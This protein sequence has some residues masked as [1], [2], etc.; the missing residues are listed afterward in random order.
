MGTD[1]LLADAFGEGEGGALR[2]AAGVYEDEGRAV[3]LDELG[4]AVVHVAPLLAGGDG[5]EVCG[6]DFD[7]DL[8]VALVASVDDGAVGSDEC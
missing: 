8:E 2:Q 4:E 7:F 6:W 5:L 3:L 1:M